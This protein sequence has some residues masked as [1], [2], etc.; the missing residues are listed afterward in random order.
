LIFGF[1]TRAF[2]SR[3]QP[4]PSFG[5]ATSTGSPAAFCLNPLYPNEIPI[6]N[7]PFPAIFA[8]LDPECVYWAMLP[9][10]RS[11]YFHPFFSPM[12]WRIAD[13]VRKPVPEEAGFGMTT[14][15]LYSG[16]TRFEYDF[17]IGRLF[18]PSS[19]VFPTKPVS[20]ALIPT[21]WASLFFPSLNPFRIFSVPLGLYP[22]S[23][24]FLSQTRRLVRAVPQITSAWGVLLLREELRRDD[25][26]GVPHD[27]EQDIGVFRLEVLPIH[28]DLVVLEGRVDRQLRSDRPGGGPGD[29]RRGQH[30]RHQ[31]PNRFRFHLF[32]S[33]SVFAQW[34]DSTGTPH[35]T[36][37]EARRVPISS[38]TRGRSPMPSTV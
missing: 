6:G 3:S 7:S 17:G 21:Q 27:L 5:K 33:S 18:L 19:T 16:L 34:C 23:I 12:S 25:P 30:G 35:G 11:R 15:P 37:P 1:R 29:E 22:A 31:D 9:S 26:R 2:D 10:S 24:P 13:T 38:T 36:S 14:S 20:Q 4:H 32:T 28:R 8:G